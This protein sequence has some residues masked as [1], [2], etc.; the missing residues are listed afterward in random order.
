MK[1]MNKILQNPQKSLLIVVL[2]LSFNTVFAQRFE[3]V[4]ALKTAYIT[5]RLDLTPAKAE[6]FWP[7]Y[8]QYEKE[9]H[10]YQVVDRMEII[11]QIMESGGVKN[12][13]EKAAADLLQK[14]LD[15]DDKIHNTEK[16]KY[17]ALKKVI[18]SSK[19]ITLIK[20]EE[21]FKKEL[22]RLLQ[23]QKDKD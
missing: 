1:R 21:G 18:P 7:I 4:K 9:L 17:L 23:A 13:S 3:K 20:A 14:V 5:D 6:K 10:Q 2:F 15:L 16:N 11:R 19:I 8:N 22:F 12:M